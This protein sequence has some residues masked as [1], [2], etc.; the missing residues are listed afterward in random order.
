MST[1]NKMDTPTI[2]ILET[3]SSSI[4]DS[5]SIYQLTERIK[6]NYGS[7]YYSNIYQKLQELKSEGL[8]NLEPTLHRQ[9]F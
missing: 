2:R 9:I 3:I 8:L 4:G 5:L 1:G 7:A 6:E